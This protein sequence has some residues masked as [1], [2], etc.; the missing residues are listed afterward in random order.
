MGSSNKLV[1]TCWVFKEENFLGLILGRGSNQEECDNS[2][3]YPDPITWITWQQNKLSSLLFNYRIISE[4]DSEKVL[5]LSSML[6]SPSFTCEKETVI[7]F[8]SQ[9]GFLLWS[10]IVKVPLHHIHNLLR[11]R[12]RE[13]ERGQQQELTMFCEGWRSPKEVPGALCLQSLPSPSGTTYSTGRLSLPQVWWLNLPQVWWADQRAL[14]IGW[15]S[16]Q[17]AYYE[18]SWHQ[19]GE[20]SIRDTES[21]PLGSEKQVWDRWKELSSCWVMEGRTESHNSWR[22]EWGSNDFWQWL[23]PCRGLM[24]QALLKFSSALVI[25]PVLP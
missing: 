25:W 19:L 22:W 10:N 18:P 1:Q 7:I 8:R 21:Q 16:T 24:L 3:M 9:A 5:F 4:Q 13:G 20:D 6:H 11:E 23:A 15:L 14:D 17:W 12:E 2:V